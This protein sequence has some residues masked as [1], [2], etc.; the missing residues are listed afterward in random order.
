MISISPNRS[1]TVK[2]FLDF[3]LEKATIAPNVRVI[4]QEG[5]E[6][7][8][9]NNKQILQ[10]G[11]FVVHPYS[12]IRHPFY[13]SLAFTEA[14]VGWLLN[15]K[16]PVEHTVQL[17]INARAKC[18]LGARLLE[19]LRYRFCSCHYWQVLEIGAH[20]AKHSKCKILTVKLPI[21]MRA[22]CRLGAR[23]LEALRYICIY[24]TLC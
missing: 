15:R 21:N 17:P 9:I 8:G 14:A 5:T 3:I 6:K 20:A 18:K 12:A 23:L 13:P 16:H 2:P 7:E 11:S 4:H 24:P 22:E 10:T 1:T 19:A